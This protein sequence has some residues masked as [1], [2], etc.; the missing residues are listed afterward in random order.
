MEGEGP[1]V[2]HLRGILPYRL[3]SVVSL[4]KEKRLNGLN[5]WSGW[6]KESGCASNNKRYETHMSIFVCAM[7]PVDKTYREATH[8]TL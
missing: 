6:R 2:P 7:S 4:I 5:H 1:T 3:L 8:S